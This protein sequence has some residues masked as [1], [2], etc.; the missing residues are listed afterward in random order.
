MKQMR[1]LL[2]QVRRGVNDGCS[3]VERLETARSG[4]ILNLS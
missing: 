1:G 3:K 4:H 2:P